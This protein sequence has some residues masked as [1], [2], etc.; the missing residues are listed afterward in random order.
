VIVVFDS[1]T[2]ISEIGLRSSA[3]SA[4]KFYLKQEGARIGL[5]EVIRKEATYGLKKHLQNSITRIRAEHRKLLAGVGQLKELVL[6][7][8]SGVDSAVMQIFDSLRAYILDVPLSVD[9]A[10]SA[11]MKCVD[12]LPP[13]DK[14]EEFRDAIIWADCMQLL[15]TDDVYFV[16]SDKA[17]FK[18]RKYESGLAENLQQELSGTS[19]QLQIF[20]DLAALLISIRKPVE[21]QIEEILSQYLSTTPS[22]LPKNELKFSKLEGGSVE[23]F[24]TEA[25]NQ[26][27]LKFELRLVCSDTSGNGLSDAL[28]VVKGEGTYDASSRRPIISRLWREEIKWLGADRT[29]PAEIRMYAFAEGHL[30]HKDVAHTIRHRLNDES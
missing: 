20:P 24:A 6:P 26:L 10:R 3:A 21:V 27:Y 22:L 1:N 15:N 18:D 14:C 5:P 28:L 8:E 11:L 13:C 12:G 2:W 19:N 9:S 25:S 30:G 29:S 17:F 7:N 16:T 4:V 23:A